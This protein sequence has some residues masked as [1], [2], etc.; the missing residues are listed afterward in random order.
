VLEI[1]TVAPTVWMLRFSVVN[2][3]AVAID[4]GFALVDTG[5]VGSEGPV[6]EALAELRPSASLRQIVLTHSH[7]DH[8]GSALALASV[9]GAEVL[10]GADDA[11][12]ISG[13]EQEP[14]A[15]ITDEERPYYERVAPLLPPAPPV[16]VDR[17]LD[18]GDDV[19][20]DEPTCVMRAPGHTAGSI[21][22]YMAASRVLFTGDNVASMA[23]RAVLGPFNVDRA[24]A[25]ASFRRQAAVD[26]EIACFGHGD[27]IIGDAVNALRQTA[28]QL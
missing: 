22:V 2:A 21:A 5:P 13:A 7:K 27:P 15:V 10:A 26:A 28:R 3:Y 11:L 16:R 14:A 25:I 23:G 20:W 1:V 18:D 4:G 8:C 12:V 24:G 9:T 19:G 17:L 6:L